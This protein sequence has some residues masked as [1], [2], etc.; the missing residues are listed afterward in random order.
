LPRKSHSRHEEKI[1]KRPA[2]A[3]DPIMPSDRSRVRD[4]GHSVPALPCRQL[5]RKANAGSSAQQILSRVLEVLHRFLCVGLQHVIEAEQKR[6]HR[7]RDATPEDFIDPIA[8]KW[9]TIMRYPGLGPNSSTALGRLL[10]QPFDKSHRAT[11]VSGDIRQG[12]AA[13]VPRVDARPFGGWYLACSRPTPH[14]A[15]ILHL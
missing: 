12:I 13:Q 2:Y 5:K 1:E 10:Q 6:H 14:F 9:A 3:T 4:D 15:G 8:G 7:V 11:V